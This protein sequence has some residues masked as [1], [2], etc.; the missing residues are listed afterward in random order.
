[1]PASP[2]RRL[3]LLLGLLLALFWSALSLSGLLARPEWVFYHGLFEARG[4]LARPANVTVVG[5]DEAS[6]E[7]LGVWPPPRTV[8]AEL[9]DG[10]LDAGAAVVALDVVF[11]QS[12]SP[13]TD[14]ALAAALRRHPGKVV[15]AANFQ[16]V[17]AGH[18]EGEKLLLPLTPFRRAAGTGFVNLSYDADGA[19][20]RFVP[21]HDVDL[22]DASLPKHFPS[23][24][25]AIAQSYMLG[26]TPQWLTDQPGGWLIDY[27]GPPGHFQ[28]ASLTKVL[29]AI[30]RHDQTYLGQFKGGIALVG[31]TSLRLQ[32]QYPTPYS[33]TVLGGGSATYMP[34]VE[35]HA[36]VVNTLLTG[37]PIRR[38]PDG[39]RFGLMLLLGVAGAWALTRLK[40][41]AGAAASV[42]VTVGLVALAAG[43]FS[44]L[45][46]WLDVTSPLFLLASLYV[47]A[48]IEHFT[49]AELSRQYVRKTFEA[50]VAP[51]IVG[52]LL[53][54]PGLA[55]KL[56]GERR[57]V[58][59]LFSDVRNFTTISEQRQ[60]EE[61][62]EFLNAYLTAMADVI[63]EQQG[64]IDKYIGDAILAIWGNV[65]PMS[66][67]DAA[68]RAVRAALG[69]KAKVEEL[70][71]QWEARGFPYID[72]GIGVN[73]GDAVVGNIGSPRKME[74]G[75][76]GDSINVA[77]RLEGLT[78]N[79]GGAILISGRTREL[80]GE[81]FACTF[82]EFVKVKGREQPV[83]IY[84][85]D[86]ELAP[87]EAVPRPA[88]VSA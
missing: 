65:A 79:Y 17:G 40:P 85:V 47:A 34:G 43:L 76:I 26:R 30:A 21:F 59:V 14:E 3:P 60:P 1:M 19:I 50:Y 28:S 74:F 13:E 87:G 46:L 61:V 42:A 2:R 48:V 10:L 63:L 16:P 24:D 73:T 57:E 72:I 62:V 22:A 81:R 12:Q 84:K 86:R 78:K 6:L 83:E 56:G 66:S 82:L 27:A 70:R 88:D 18:D 23:F 77:S 35:I 54:N 5:I 25:V 8:F 51:E 41:W 36:N 55:P 39:V 64:C 75:V 71:P 33:A 7:D 20:H 52:E 80:I 9:I 45:R 69:M 58:S 4:P 15:L 11:P 38:V 53:K 32:D 49:R 67:E 31:A 29:E 68:T 44:A 37:H